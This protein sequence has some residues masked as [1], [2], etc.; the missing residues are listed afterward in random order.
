[1]KEWLTSKASTLLVGGAIAVVLLQMFV[2]PALDF[3]FG[4]VLVGM[5]V[6]SAYIATKKK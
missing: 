4:L 6:G 3:V 5:V 2:R 1:M